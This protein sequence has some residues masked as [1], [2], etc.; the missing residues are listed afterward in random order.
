MLNK[1]VNFQLFLYRSLKNYSHHKKL[2]NNY[3]RRNTNLWKL[4]NDSSEISAVLCPDY[5]YTNSEYPSIPLSD[6]TPSGKLTLT[7]KKP[8]EQHSGISPK[9][10]VKGCYCNSEPNKIRL[11][12]SRTQHKPA[13]TCCRCKSQFEFRSNR[14]TDDKLILSSP[15][16]CETFRRIQKI[17]YA[18]RSQFLRNVQNKIYLRDAGQGDCLRTCPRSSSYHKLMASTRISNAISNGDTKLS[19]EYRHLNQIQ[20]SPS[21]LKAPA[22]SL[23][24]EQ[25]ECPHTNIHISTKDT[26]PSQTSSFRKT[27]TSKKQISE[28]SEKQRNKRTTSTYKKNCS[29][30]CRNR[31]EKTTRFTADKDRKREDLL[32]YS[33]RKSQYLKHDDPVI[34][35]FMDREI[36]DMRKFREQNYFDTHGS[37][38]TLASSKSSGSLQQYLLNERLFPEPVR[39]IHKQDLVVTMPPCSTVQRKRVHYFP[40]YVVQQEKS[41]CNTNYKKKRHQNC[42]LTGHAIDLGVLKIRPPLNSLALKHQ[43]KI[44]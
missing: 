33:N 32:T 14:E 38:H 30:C 2:Q 43:K 35:D 24:S 3:I 26:L 18:P 16:S 22:N 1:N 4:R 39:I 21:Y 6:M 44:P 20:K 40:K 31:T 36:E 10:A 42:P 37:S 23:I 19:N 12:S 34:D 9:K 27:I 29:C 11:R 7:C 5:F 25:S 13:S 8:E 41:T 28:P 15:I 17:D